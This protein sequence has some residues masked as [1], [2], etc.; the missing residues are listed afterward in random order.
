MSESRISSR[1][2][3]DLWFLHWVTH[4]LDS[5]FASSVSYDSKMSDPRHVCSLSIEDEYRFG[6]TLEEKG[7]LGETS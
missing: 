5:L 6:N 7:D 1:M 3:L 2:A 4:F